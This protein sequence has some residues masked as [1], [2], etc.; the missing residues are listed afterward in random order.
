MNPQSLNTRIRRNPTQQE[1]RALALQYT[2]AMIE[3]RCGNLN[4]IARNKARMAQATYLIA[5]EA[6]AAEFSGKVMNPGKADQLI[7]AQRRYL[8]AQ[9]E[10]IVIEGYYG[11]GKE[12]VAVEWIYSPEAANIAGMQQILAF[13][14]AAVESEAQLN[15]PF[16]P[17]FH[18]IYTPNC[19]ADGVPQ[20]QAILVDLD[21]HT[22]YIMGPDYFGE[23]KKAVLRMLCDYMYDRGALV[24]H[25]GAKV[26]E[27]GGERQTMAVMGLSGTGK[28]TTTF[29]KQGR[30]THPVQDDM[31]TLW[32]S[33]QYTVTENGCFAKTAGLTPESEPVIYDGTTHPSAW[34]ENVYVN[35]DKTYDFSKTRLS[36]EEVAA[37]QDVLVATGAAKAN[38][39]AYIAGTV[40]FEDLLDANG[41]PKD[42]WDFVLWTQNG[43]S[44]IPL[45]AIKDAADLTSLPPIRSM[46]TLNRDEGPDAATPG[47]VRFAS[48]AQ[49]AGYF[50]LGE[51]TKTSAAGKERGK[52]RSPFTQ[53][54]FPRAHSLQAERFNALAATMP[55]CAMWMM[56]TGFVG[57]DAR[58][59]AAG[60][61]LKVK[62]KHSSAMLEALLANAVVWKR[63]PDFGYEIVDVDAP[64]NAA[65]LR[66]VSAE[67]LEPRRFFEAQGRQTLYRDWVSRMKTERRAF[68]EKY[69]VDR[70]IIQTVAQ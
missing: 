10:L 64:R 24:L 41:T 38:V 59:V 69:G 32:P 3:T 20:N 26:V 27:V 70:D 45:A 17:R 25:A 29:S 50:M 22:T 57:G 21:R 35:P 46:G 34:V 56:N 49:A 4:K 52:T 19:A 12:A 44:I 66:Q 7:A 55:G 1:L 33:G 39:E 30:L 48:P 11:L 5:D 51:T 62:I 42:G 23:S 40:R 53:P 65:L 54:F 6:R 18:A 9:P 15:K 47:I 67:I 14:R 43:R 60:K 37:M 63:D 28:T 61:A 36:P 2:P 31:I 8:E 68:L 16:A 13:P 58:D